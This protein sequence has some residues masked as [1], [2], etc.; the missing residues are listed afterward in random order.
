MTYPSLQG[1]A[2]ARRMRADETRAS[3][4]T[5][6]IANSKDP[7]AV[8]DKWLTSLTAKDLAAAAEAKRRQ[9]ELYAARSATLANSSVSRID[10]LKQ[11]IEG[12]GGLVK[13]GETVQM[14]LSR[15]GK[16]RKQEV[17][18][19]KE[20][21]KR[22]RRLNKTQRPKK[23]FDAPDEQPP[24]KPATTTPAE[25]VEKH[26]MDLEN[27]L[28]PPQPSAASIPSAAKGKGREN[29]PISPIKMAIDR[30]TSLAST[31]LGTHGETDIYEETHEGIIRQLIAE[32]EVP[33]GW[34]PN[35]TASEKS[36]E[37]KGNGE[38]GTSGGTSDKGSKGR[39]S[40]ISRPLIARPRS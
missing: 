5:A 35:N 21:L 40:V 17:E 30:L 33:R 22:E 31:L 1:N 8:H 23:D 15:L 20:R 27:P 24:T 2:G 4:H 36:T 7:D 28:S 32:G 13:E 26:D 34:K 10:C 37:E 12:D 39:R 6:Y 14:A 11:L 38:S 9:D 29:E 25:N 3:H 16:A 19:E 18:E